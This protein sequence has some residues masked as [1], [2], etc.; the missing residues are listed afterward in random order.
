MASR[1][2]ALTENLSNYITV[3]ADRSPALR[4]TQALNMTSF[5]YMNQTSIHKSIAENLI[6]S[7]RAIGSPEREESC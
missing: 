1:Q 6:G 3:P 7:D 2:W 4:S 5:P